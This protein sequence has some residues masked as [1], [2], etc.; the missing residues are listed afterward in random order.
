MASKRRPPR[1]PSREASRQKAIAAAAKGLNLRECAAAAGVKYPTLRSWLYRGRKEED[2][3]YAAFAAEFD[4]IRERALR[5]PLTRADFTGEL[6][7]AVRA[8]SVQAMKLWWEMNRD[9]EDED[10]ASKDE[11]PKPGFDELASRRTAGTS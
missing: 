4:E 7:R 5:R 2:G 3:T 9:G 11:T 8:G 6:A 1:R 10:E